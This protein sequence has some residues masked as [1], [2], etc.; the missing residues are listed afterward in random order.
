V[1]PQ[2]VLLRAADLIEERGH[3]HGR[4]QDKSGRLCASGAMR[5]AALGSAEAQAPGGTDAD[6]DTFYAAYRLLTTSIPE[7]GGRRP[8]V[9]NWSDTSTKRQVVRVLRAAA[10][11]P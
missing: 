2:E 8:S 9:V 1:T 11:Q 3:C 6:A 7:R 5:L 4:Y 10:E